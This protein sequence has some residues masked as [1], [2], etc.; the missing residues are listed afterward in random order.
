MSHQLDGSRYGSS[1]RW[2]DV[3]TAGVTLLVM[4]VSTA[5]D[6]GA[7]ITPEVGKISGNATVS[8]VD[9]DDHG[10]DHGPMQWIRR[11]SSNFNLYMHRPS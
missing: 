2:I 4:T 11:C 5:T 10:H 7:V 3:P 1:I 9:E 6:T 8:I